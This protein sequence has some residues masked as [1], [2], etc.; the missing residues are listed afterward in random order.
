MNQ[1]KEIRPEEI[2][3]NPFALIGTDWALITTKDNEKYNAMTI[4][5]GALGVMWNKKVVFVAVRP[6]RHTYHLMENEPVFSLAFFD[7]CYK[8]QLKYC[9]KVSGKEF[10]KI[11]ECNFDISMH[12]D[13][14][15]IRQAKL[16]LTCK[17]I[18]TSDID[19]AKFIDASIENNY[20]MKDYHQMYICEITGV[21]VQN[22]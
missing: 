9:G 5:W 21:L 6:T 2:T 13:T 10:D 3:E 22:K 7:E 12:K 8:E 16:V 15:F 20:P 11:K 17:K 4:S 14:P 18:A 19:P 1:F